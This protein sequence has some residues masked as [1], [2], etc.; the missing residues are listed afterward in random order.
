M[1][2]TGLTEKKKTRKKKSQ[3]FSKNEMSVS[4]SSSHLNPV[5]RFYLIKVLFKSTEKIKIL[6]CL[7]KSPILPVLYGGQTPLP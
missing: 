3:G 7:G 4:Y 6:G 5:D 2:S 1:I